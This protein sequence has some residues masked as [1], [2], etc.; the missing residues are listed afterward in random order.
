MV[1]AAFLVSLLVG[2]LGVAWISHQVLRLNRLEAEARAQA[3]LEEDVRL[4]LWRMDSLLAPIFARE[5]ARPYFSYSAFYPAERAYTRMYTEMPRGGVLI[6][7]RLL[8]ETQPF[9]IQHFQFAP[10]GELSS[11]QVPTGNVSDRA[12]T[13][14]YLDKK[15]LDEAIRKLRKLGV[16]VKRDAL[17]GRLPAPNASPLQLDESLGRTTWGEEAKSASPNKAPETG[18]Y[19]LRASQN[20]LA[21]SNEG[22]LGN[23]AKQS[24]E[25]QQ[26]QGAFQGPALV[27]PVPQFRRQRPRLG[28]EPEE[29]INELWNA[30]PPEGPAPPIA[31]GMFQPVWIG[32]ALLA[33][34]RVAVGDKEYVQGFQLDWPALQTWLLQ[35]VGDLLEDATLEPATESN[36]DGRHQM[37][38]SLPARLIPGPRKSSA[39]PA[40]TPLY[41]SLFAAWIGMGIAVASVGLLLRGAVVLGERRGA[42]VSSVTH[43]LRTP[44]TTFRMYTEMLAEGMVPSEATRRKYL[45]TLRA[46]AD[47]L[48]HLVENVLSYA[49][50]ER[51]RDGG[52]ADAVL[53][54]D[55]LTRLDD[56]LKHRTAESEMEWVRD[57]KDPLLSTVLLV[58]PLAVEQIVFNLVD[59]ACKYACG[60]KD[61]RIELTIR[62]STRRRK[63]L[64]LHVR[65][66]GPGISK[67]GLNRVFRLFRKSATDAAHSAPGVG[68]G[69]AL[70]RRLARK[71]GGDLRLCEPLP[72]P[73]EG[74]CFA[75]TLPIA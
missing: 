15:K 12:E 58:D 50:L 11:P 45:T 44:L 26:A 14:G 40:K 17:M 3:A 23:N 10:D 49:R 56:R 72:M 48:A 63:S 75:L 21:M 42:F 65:D 71:M 74:A 57:R 5:S 41:L 6:P 33:A 70:S 73:G 62:R 1:A 24:V 9:I 13:D 20:R 31:E 2:A 19:R 34:R 28:Q 16:F 64:V 51:G 37:L 8:T 4:A 54:G 53:L 22:N 61:R 46:E 18:D 38:A 67:S 60:S 43:E 30:V 29:V 59:N 32:E 36:A 7:S 35:H 68:L 25:Q 47:R 52:R 55:L 39:D 66:Y 69:L 27:V